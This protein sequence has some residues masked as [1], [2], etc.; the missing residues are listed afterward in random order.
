[1]T[2]KEAAFEWTI[3][4]QNNKKKPALAY[5][6]DGAVKKK[7][8]HVDFFS[9]STRQVCITL[10]LYLYILHLLNSKMTHPYCRE[11]WY[12]FFFFLTS[13]IIVSC[14]LCVILMLLDSLCFV[15]L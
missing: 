6:T 10:T 11:S 9:S 7:H 5:L 8:E 14:V 13:H 1:M 3:T 12:F 2:K 4:A 15:S